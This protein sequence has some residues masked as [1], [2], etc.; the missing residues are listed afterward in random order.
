MDIADFGGFEGGGWGCDGGFVGRRG[1]FFGKAVGSTGGFV[2]TLG[3]F[4]FLSCFCVDRGS[5]SCEAFGV[6]EALGAVFQILLFGLLVVFV[7]ET[8]I[9]EH[10]R[11]KN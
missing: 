7:V 9:I 2:L 3:I 11:S 10:S 4:L 1:W 8:E 5:V 6:A